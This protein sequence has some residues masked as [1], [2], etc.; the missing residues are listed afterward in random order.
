MLSRFPFEIPSTVKCMALF[1][2]FMG[3]SSHLPVPVCPEGSASTLGLLIFDWSLPVFQIV[4]VVALEHGGPR[5]FSASQSQGLADIKL[6]EIE[7]V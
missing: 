7:S 2:L 6:A 5:P 3:N 4:I 1:L